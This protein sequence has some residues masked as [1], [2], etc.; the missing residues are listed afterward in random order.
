MSRPLVGTVLASLLLASAADAQIVRRGTL[1][2]ADR[3]LIAARAGEAAR[4][5]VIDAQ[6]PSGAVTRVA[7][8]I[9]LQG[10]T[11]EEKFADLLATYGPIF[12]LGGSVTLSP[13]RVLSRHG[14]GTPRHLRATQLVHGA[15]VVGHSI[16]AEIDAAGR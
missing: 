7:G 10:V 5:W 13:P 3:A 12:D 16:T 8:K 2:D 15:E 1:R 6:A 9:A 11:A 4:S 14:D